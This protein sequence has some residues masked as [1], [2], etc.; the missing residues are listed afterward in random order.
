MIYVCSRLKTTVN[1]NLYLKY[2]VPSLGDDLEPGVSAQLSQHQTPSLLHP[3]KTSDVDPDPTHI[4]LSSRI[5]IAKN[6]PK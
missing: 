3:I 6:Q 5:R 1:Q 2:K 4:I